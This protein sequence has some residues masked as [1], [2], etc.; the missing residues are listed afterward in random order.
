MADSIKFANRYGLNVKITPQGA[1][2]ATPVE[3]DFANS[4]ALDVNGERVWATGGQGHSNKIAFND[5]I[6]GTF[7]ISTQLM[8]TELLAII[9][10]KASPDGSGEVVFENTATSPVYFTI[11]ADTVW[12]TEGGKTYEESI[13]IHK[14]CPKRAYNISYT[15]EGDPASIDIEF[16]VLEDAD[17]KV[18]T[19][20]KAEK[21]A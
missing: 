21:T 12:Q 1:D 5:P 17:K 8:T 10:G 4:C 2:T 19:I 11:E 20:N 3:V 13:T 16:D 7:T 14:A 9:A 6:Q 15:G 18:V